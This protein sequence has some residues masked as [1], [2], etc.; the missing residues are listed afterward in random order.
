MSNERIQEQDQF[1]YIY[2]LNFFCAPGPGLGV[3]ILYKDQRLCLPNG[4]LAYEAG[5][6]SI[7]ALVGFLWGALSRRGQLR[8]GW[9]AHGI[10]EMRAVDVLSQKLTFQ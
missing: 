7:N 8:V 9:T 4:T 3:G 2:R 10:K 5:S 6:V 1:I